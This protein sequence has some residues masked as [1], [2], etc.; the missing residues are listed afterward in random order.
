MR[1]RRLGIPTGLMLLLLAAAAPGAARQPR[2]VRLSWAPTAPLADLSGLDLEGVG[3]RTIELRPFAD[4]RARTDRIGELRD[5][6]PAV[7]PVTT[8]DDVAGWVSG[9]V[10]DLFARVGLRRVESG[11]DVVLGGAVRSLL[12]TERGGLDAEVAL[13]VEV[14]TGGGERLWDGLV[15]GS[16]SGPRRFDRDR[17]YSEALSNAVASAVV[18]LFEASGFTEALG[19][20]EPEEEEP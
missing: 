4:E 7:Y 10:A 9:G 18:R 6:E 12:V 13:W 19:T 8:R 15:L 14:R 1:V 2:P 17:G 16:S 20:P 11:G 3:G 5:D